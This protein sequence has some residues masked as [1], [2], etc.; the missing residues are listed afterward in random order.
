MSNYEEYLKSIEWKRLRKKAYMRAKGK[1]EFCGEK[2]IEVHHVQY[3]KNGDKD[4]LD[5]LV[6]VCKKHHDLCHGIR[7]S[8]N[9][10][11]VIKKYK[12]FCDGCHKQFDIEYLDMN[13]GK[14]LCGECED[15]LYKN[16]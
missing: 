10:K 11:I 8:K 1:C 16:D 15:F 14:M 13:D 9:K 3:P 2:A 6:A 4:S 7:K 12:E 5:N